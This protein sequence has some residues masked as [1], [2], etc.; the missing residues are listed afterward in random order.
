MKLHG[1]ALA[2]YIFDNSA[3]HH[4]ID[5][6]ALNAKKLNL[7]YGGKNTPILIDVFYIHQNGHR[8]VHTMLTA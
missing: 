1:G 7:K 4:K 6:E 3:N 2:L 5:T 8:V